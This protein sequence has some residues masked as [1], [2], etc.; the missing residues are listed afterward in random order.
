MQNAIQT[1]IEFGQQASALATSAGVESARL[2][3]AQE[4]LAGIAAGMSVLADEAAEVAAGFQHKL[5]VVESDLRPP[6]QMIMLMTGILKHIKE[7]SEA[8]ENTL[9]SERAASQSFAVSVGEAVGAGTRI[10]GHIVALA[11]AIQTALPRLRN[12]R[13]VEDELSHL[14]SE[15][16]DFVEHFRQRRGNIGPAVLE[17]TMG[18]L[19]GKPPSVN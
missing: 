2:R 18:P 1:I 16:H 14:T 8:V 10:A 9:Q 13:K 17:A 12:K 15:L 3:A 7:L 11:Q 19:L 6:S 4:R 5:V